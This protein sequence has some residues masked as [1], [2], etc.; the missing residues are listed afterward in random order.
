MVKILN[1]CSFVALFLIRPGPGYTADE[2]GEGVFIAPD[3]F[4]L[5]PSLQVH[6]RKDHAKA[7]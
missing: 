7:Q 2:P 1:L 6:G 5:Y 4:P 3:F